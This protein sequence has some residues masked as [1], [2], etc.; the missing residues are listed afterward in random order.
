MKKTDSGADTGDGSAPLR[1]CTACGLGKPIS[2]FLKRKPPRRGY[3]PRC[4]TCR[5]EAGKEWRERPGV[6]EYQR[7]YHSR[8][9]DKYHTPAAKRARG[10]E[11]RRHGMTSAERQ[12]MLDGQGGRCKS[13]GDEIKP[14]SDGAFGGHVDHDHAH[15][16]GKWGCKTCVRAI[17]CNGCNTSLGSLR[18]D[19]DRIEKLKQYAIRYC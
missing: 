9:F 4:K 18:E 2:D 7:E 17:L 19:P 12:L 1:H 14:R 16:P 13:C 8:H 6:T 15:C 5:A 11:E 3:R 10:Y